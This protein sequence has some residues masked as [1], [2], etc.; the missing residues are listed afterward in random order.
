MVFILIQEGVMRKG[1]WGWAPR[2]PF[3]AVYFNIPALI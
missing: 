2:G 1:G 3:L